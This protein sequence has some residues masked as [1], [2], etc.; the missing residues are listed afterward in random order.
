MSRARML[1]NT[2]FTANIRPSRRPWGRPDWNRASRLDGAAISC[3]ALYR[4]G[5]KSATGN[6]NRPPF[7]EGLT[8]ERRTAR[9]FFVNLTVFSRFPQQTTH[10]VRRQRRRGTIRSAAGFGTPCP[11]SPPRSQSAS[12]R[13]GALYKSDGLSP[14]FR[15]LRYVQK[16]PMPPVHRQTAATPHKT[17]EG[18]SA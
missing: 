2:A 1:F 5:A 14:V 9:S 16:N 18:V 12:C 10:F 7:P 8:K 6:S 11:N 4:S 15:F 3:F 17:L 13:Q